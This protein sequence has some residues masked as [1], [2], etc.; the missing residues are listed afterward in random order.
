MSQG[1]KVIGTADL[2]EKIYSSVR[3]IAGGRYSYQIKMIS[4][5]PGLPS[6]SSMYYDYPVPSPVS[7]VLPADYSSIDESPVGDVAVKYTDTNYTIASPDIESNPS[8]NVGAYFTAGAGFGK[9]YHASKTMQSAINQQNDA[10]NNLL[11]YTSS[12]TAMEPPSSAVKSLSFRSAQLPLPLPLILFAAAGAT[13]WFVGLIGSIICSH[14]KCGKNSTLLAIIFGIMSGVGTLV[15]LISGVS[16]SGYL[17]I[18]AAQANAGAGAQVIFAR[19]AE[20]GYRMA[21]L[22]IPWTLAHTAM[23]ADIESGWSPTPIIDHL[24]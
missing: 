3:G 10:Y 7:T 17:T 20:W 8:S 16:V 1:G 6:S 9:G 11:H 23:P 5:V 21:R 13:M 19:G 4:T 18:A 2:S 14:N 15:T 22:G 12:S 24:D